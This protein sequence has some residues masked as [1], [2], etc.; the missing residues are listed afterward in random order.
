VRA[1]KSGPGRDILVLNSASIIQTLL[2]EDLV[3]DLYLTVVPTILG[4][5]LQLLPDGDASTWQ[6]A[7]ATAFPSSGAVALH[8]QR[9]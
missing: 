8:Y 7:S 9:P 5:G 1:L 6:L 4:G 2:K 3:D